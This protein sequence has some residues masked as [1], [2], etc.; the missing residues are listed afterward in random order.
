VLPV[1]EGQ[2]GHPVIFSATLYEELL[3]APLDTGARSVVWA[4][5]GDV[6][7]VQ[8]NEE[9]CILNLND[10]GTMQRALGG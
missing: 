2:R 5:S 8:T 6:Q 1:Y 3:N 4:H 7:I 10:P 9:G